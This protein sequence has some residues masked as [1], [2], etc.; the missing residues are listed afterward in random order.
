MTRTE[1]FRYLITGWSREVS[2]R[3][4]KGTAKTLQIYGFIRSLCSLR[5]DFQA[6]ESSK[7][8]IALSR[9]IVRD[10]ADLLHLL[11]GAPNKL[12]WTSFDNRSRKSA[13]LLRTV[14]YIT[15]LQISHYSANLE[16]K[17]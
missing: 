4:P 16:S 8:L 6:G 2:E 3:I 1:P 9:K 13:L 17:N 7:A 10:F 14:S 5:F 11:L 12:C 15:S